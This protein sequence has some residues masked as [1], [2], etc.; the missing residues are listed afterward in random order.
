MKPI[1]KKLYKTLAKYAPGNSLRV[2]L[3]RACGYRIGTGVYL[4]EDM[5]V[6][7]ILEDPSEKLILGDRVSVGP[8][9]TF[10]T[11]SDPNKSRLAPEFVQPVRGRIV[12]GS[13]AWI[14]AGAIILPNVTIG[15]RAIVGAGAVV[16]QDVPAL[17]VVVGVPAKVVRFIGRRESAPLVEAS[18]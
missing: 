17:A 1:L 16:T 2:G 12:V 15:E 14:G 8:R 10:V 3:F 7:E 4:A 13:D 9:V 18:A 11:A 5:I 6:T